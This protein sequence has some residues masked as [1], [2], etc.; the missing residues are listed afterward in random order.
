MKIIS[1][2][3]MFLLKK[4]YKKIRWIFAPCPFQIL[5]HVFVKEIFLCMDMRRSIWQNFE[6]S[7]WPFWKYQ[8]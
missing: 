3:V 8:H 5:L 2:H 7:S 1:I 6:N 4:I